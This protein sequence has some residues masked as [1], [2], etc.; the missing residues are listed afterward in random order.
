MVIALLVGAGGFIGAIARYGV[1]SG[2]AKLLNG[3]WLPYGT[4][5]VNV[6]GCLIIGL[7]A[8]L[9]DH[10][11]IGSPELRAFILIGILGGFTTYSAFGYETINLFREGQITAAIVNVAIQIVL[12]LGAVWVGYKL[13]TV[14]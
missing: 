1:N 9:I 10:R 14:G 13:A 4:L 8:G 2:F 6:V 7:V 11:Q 12:G 3:Q 5:T